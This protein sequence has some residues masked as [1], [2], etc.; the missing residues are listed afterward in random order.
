M[1]KLNSTNSA[2]STHAP[3]AVM[4]EEKKKSGS[5]M[6]AAINGM[7]IISLICLILG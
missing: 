3:H 6:I 4:N 5:D 7:R 1:T 2:Y